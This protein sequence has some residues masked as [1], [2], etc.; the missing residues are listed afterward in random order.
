MEAERRGQER[1]DCQGDSWQAGHGQLCP[2]PILSLGPAG[3]GTGAARTL[4][5]SVA[6]GQAPGLRSLAGLGETGK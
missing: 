2:L 5:A 3:L 1:S 6:G 4:T